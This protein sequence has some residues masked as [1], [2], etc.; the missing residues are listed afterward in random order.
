MAVKKT[1]LYGLT[2]KPPDNIPDL[3]PESNGAPFVPCT[4]EANP[5]L[6]A[7]GGDV[8]NITDQTKPIPNV[9]YGVDVV[10]DRVGIMPLRCAHAIYNFANDGG[11]AG[12]IT[13][14]LTATIPANAILI[15]AT[16]NPTTAVTSGGSATVSVGTTAGSSATSILGATAKTSLTIDALVNGAVTLASPVKMSAAGSINITV[17]TAALTAGLIEIFVYYIVA[18]NA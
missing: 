18:Q 10:G 12:A 9:L 8:F 14:K 2:V 11:A 1:K 4:V 3:A 5:T 6:V 7:A 17:G 15:G 16:I 13:P